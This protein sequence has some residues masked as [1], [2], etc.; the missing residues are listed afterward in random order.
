[1]DRV[2]VL[3][4]GQ[5]VEVGTPASLLA[6]PSA[7]GRLAAMVERTGPR[8]ARFMRSMAAGAVETDDTQ[9][10]ALAIA[11]EA[12]AADA[13]DA[14]E[15]AEADTGASCGTSLHALGVADHRQGRGRYGAMH[16]EAL[17]L[18]SGE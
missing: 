4:R 6:L 8:I 3:E 16:T 2:A 14:A 11:A 12:L 1:M 10:S 5:V 9:G 15:A 17:F 18:A 13:A 7:T